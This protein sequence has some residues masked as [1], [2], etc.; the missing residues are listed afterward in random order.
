M[1]GD[2]P[3]NDWN[4]LFGLLVIITVALIWAAEG[5]MVGRRVE[6]LRPQSWR[7]SVWS[8]EREAYDLELSSPW[9]LLRHSG[10]MPCVKRV[11]ECA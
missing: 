2:C 7:L 3:E 8:G 4:V 1:L 11:P 5:A 9:A 6:K 10:Q